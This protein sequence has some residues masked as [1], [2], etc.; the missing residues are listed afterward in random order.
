MLSYYVEFHLRKAWGAIS[1]ND[2]DLELHK[3]RSPAAPASRSQ[4]ALVKKE[5]KETKDGV[6][7]KGV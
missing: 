5:Y 6:E 2:T 7:C 1:F 3:T 4:E